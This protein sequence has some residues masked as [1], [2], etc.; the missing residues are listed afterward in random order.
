MAADQSMPFMSAGLWGPC[1]CHDMSAVLN[2][3]MEM[4]VITQIGGLW[5]C[6]QYTELILTLH[7]AN[8]RR[9]YFVT[10]SL[11]GWAQA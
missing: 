5:D 7:P 1:V 2:D 6:P 8:E 9:C 10:T 3:P 11:I 4:K